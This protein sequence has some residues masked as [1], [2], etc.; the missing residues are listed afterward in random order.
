MKILSNKINFTNLPKTNQNPFS[1]SSLAF[2]RQ[3]LQSDVVNFAS[4]PVFTDGEATRLLARELFSNME[5]KEARIWL[6]AMVNACKK[7]SIKPSSL[8]INAEHSGNLSK[9]QFGKLITEIVYQ[10]APNPDKIR[11]VG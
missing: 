6:K 7:H 1:K 5:P 11:L 8:P 4:K 3:K 9:E 2:G 10:T